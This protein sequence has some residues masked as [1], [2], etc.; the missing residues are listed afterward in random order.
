MP[1]Q[2]HFPA[3]VARIDAAGSADE[4]ADAAEACAVDRSDSVWL[5]TADYRLNG[6]GWFLIWR[7][8]KIVQKLEVPGCQPHDPMVS[9][10]PGSMYIL[11][12]AGLTHYV[13]DGPDFQQYHLQ[14]DYRPRD[15]SGIPRRLSPRPKDS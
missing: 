14:A 12:V 6:R 5:A 2:T 11:T 7:N 13:A 4:V 3:V 15:L 1:A 9:D 8:G 10:R